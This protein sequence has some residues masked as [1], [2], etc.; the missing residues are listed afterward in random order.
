MYYIS[1]NVLTS[2]YFLK[3][4]MNDPKDMIYE[5]IDDEKYEVIDVPQHYE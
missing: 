3:R 5:E 2:V 1:C 4:N